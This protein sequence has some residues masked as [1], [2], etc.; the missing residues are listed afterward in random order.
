MRQTMERQVEHLVRL[1]DD[2]LDVSRLTMGRI[3][4]RR[5]LVDIRDI[6]TDALDTC[7]RMLVAKGHSVTTRMPPDSLVVDGDRVRLVQIVT[8]ILNNAG[9][10]TDPGGDIAVVVSGSDESIE[11]SISDNGVGISQKRL[12]TIFAALSQKRPLA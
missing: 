2:L 12:A 10:F 6:V 3:T 7:R 5:E 1:V 8:N 9:K 4:L 11:I